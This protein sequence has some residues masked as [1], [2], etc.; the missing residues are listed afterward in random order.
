MCLAEKYVPPKNVCTPKKITP[1]NASPLKIVTHPNNMSHPISLSPKK[2]ITP[3]ALLFQLL[4]D[5]IFGT[6]LTFKACPEAA[7]NF[8]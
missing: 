4:F 2:N 7:Y 3:S 6:S 5:A 8:R 1:K